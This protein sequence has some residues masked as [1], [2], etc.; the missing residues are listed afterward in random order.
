MIGTSPSFKAGKVGCRKIDL[1][2]FTPRKIMATKGRHQICAA[3]CIP[4]RNG[5]TFKGGDL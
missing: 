5:K 1:A 3:A 4:S 2:G